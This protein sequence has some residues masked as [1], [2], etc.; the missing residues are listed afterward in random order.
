MYE[1]TK[2]LP[3]EVFDDLVKILPIP[4][5]KRYGR[6]RCQF[7]AILNGILQVLVNDVAWGKIAPCGSSYVTCY[8]YF[9]ELQRRGKLKLIFEM[10]A[11]EKTNVTESTIDSNSISSFRFRRMTGWCGKHKKVS[12]K[13][14]L[15]TDKVGL[16][17]DVAFG[18]GGADDR[19]F[20]LPHMQNGAK[21][22]RIT[23]LNLDKGYTSCDLRRELRRRGTHVNMQTR[24][25]DYIRKRG[26]KFQFKKEEYK[27]R[28]LIE[29]TF[30]WME[31][32]RH[33]KLRR[34]YHPAMYK[35]FVYLALIVILLRN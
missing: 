15:F 14:S 24:K 21:R 8:R 13:V 11:K 35:A 9:C 22:R 23:E 27:V 12:T 5:Q 19:I 10:L 29:K 28:F 2:L 16:P 3:K 25:G 6:K 32:F 17:V 31:N 1:I 34:E 30:A 7:K 18:K 33:T 20:V 4:K 26:P